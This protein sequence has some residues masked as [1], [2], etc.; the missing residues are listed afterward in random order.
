MYLKGNV[1]WASE[2][3]EN[4]VENVNYWTGILQGQNHSIKWV[5]NSSFC[6]WKTKNILHA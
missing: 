3:V 5:Q 4:S 6:Y 2:S 1:I